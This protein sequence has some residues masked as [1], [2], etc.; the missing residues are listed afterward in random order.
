MARNVV[1]VSG[2]RSPLPL[3]CLDDQ[4]LL[5]SI[6]CIS[7]SLKTACQ[8]L[9]FSGAIEAAEQANFWPCK[10]CRPET[11]GT[12]NTG[13]VAI[14]QVLR[15]IVAETFE[16]RSEMK[17]EGLKLESLAKSAG[18][19]T[20][21]FHRLFQATT[22]VTPAAFITACHTLALQDALCT[23]STRRSRPDPSA[24]QMSPRWSER[25]A[26]KA[27]GGLSTEEY[28]SGAKATSIEYCRVSAPVGDL[29]VAYSRDKKSPNVTVHAVVLLQDSSLPICNYFWTSTR[30]EEHTKSL[31][32]CVRE[33]TE[34]SQDRDVELGADLLPILWRARRWLTLIHANKLG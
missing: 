16:E 26:S 8:I 1:T 15:S 10:R 33:L 32:E 23:Y 25:T 22:R 5:P 34:K 21:H 19:S 6:V 3:R 27:L 7:T 30:S 24:V 9:L 29:E 20:F 2:S 28:A 18:L 4:D 13:V 12:G 11:P 14:S 17:N 31:Q